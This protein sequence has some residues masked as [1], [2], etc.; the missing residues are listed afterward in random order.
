MTCFEFGFGWDPHLQGSEAERKGE[1]SSR[2]GPSKSSPGPTLAALTAFL[3][4]AGRVKTAFLPNHAIGGYRPQVPKKR[5]SLRYSPGRCRVSFPVPTV[6]SSESEDC[7]T[8]GPGIQQ[9]SSSQ[10]LA[11]C[12]LSHSFAIL[13]PP[14]PTHTH[15]QTPFLCSVQLLMTPS[16]IIWGVNFRIFS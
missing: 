7:W 2:A 16:L 6:Y 8:S 3:G 15:K 11:F 10:T 4:C 1:S 12:F 14:P 13:K 9:A 5:L